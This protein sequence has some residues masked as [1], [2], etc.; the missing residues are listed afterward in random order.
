MKLLALYH[1][2]WYTFKF[3]NH[4]LPFTWERIVAVTERINKTCADKIMVVGICGTL[5]R[6]KKGKCLNEYIYS[7]K[8][9]E[10]H[11]LAS[12]KTCAHYHL[13]HHHHQPHHHHDHD[14]RR[15]YHHCH[16]YSYLKHYEIDWI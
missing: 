12:F 5:N 4:L 14:N 11:L 16:H 9:G 13:H 2:K 1:R 6:Y 8:H 15:H 7:R 10:N 3:H